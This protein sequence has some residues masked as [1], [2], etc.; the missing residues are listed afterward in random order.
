MDKLIHLNVFVI[1]RFHSVYTQPQS[2]AVVMASR[3]SVDDSDLG[4][5]EMWTSDFT[6]VL[7]VVRRA[8]S[9]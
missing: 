4:S 5:T 1:L 8:E 7:S 9:V 3:C 2:P 6:R